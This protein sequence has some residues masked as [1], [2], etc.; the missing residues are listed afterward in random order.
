[1]SSLAQAWKDL[2]VYQTFSLHCLC[3]APDT[4]AFVKRLLL[5]LVLT[6]LCPEIRADVVDWLY[7]VEVPVATQ[8]SSDPQAAA[9]RAFATVLTRITGLEDI[10]RNPMVAAALRNPE[11]F[12]LGTDLYRG[13]VV[14]TERLIT[15]QHLKSVLTPVQ[16]KTLFGARHSL[17]G[18]QI[19]LEFWLGLLWM[20]VLLALRLTATIVI[21]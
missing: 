3:L 17:F 18:V 14:S 10:P 1:M 16:Y 7:D 11:R 19:G 21:G 2:R 20:P 5:V 6:C 9:A 13:R 8:S 12:T 4:T 15:T